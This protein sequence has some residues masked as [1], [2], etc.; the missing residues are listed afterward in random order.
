MSERRETQAGSH[1]CECGG[2]QRVSPTLSPHQFHY[3]CASCTRAGTIS[4]LHSAPPPVFVPTP[5][6]GQGELF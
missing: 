4:W 2:T 1:R 5:E 3:Q 6:S